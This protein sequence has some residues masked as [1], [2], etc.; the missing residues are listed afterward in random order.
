MVTRALWGGLLGLCALRLLYPFYNSPVIQ[1]VGMSGRQ[2]KQAGGFLTPEPMAGVDS[3]LYQAWLWALR[4]LSNDHAF[5][6]QLVCGLLCAVLPLCWYA[7][8]RQLLPQKWA[9]IA[10]ILI[11]L[12][13]SF[14]TIYGYFASET[15]LLPLIGLACYASLH[16]LRT[17]AP[18]TLWLAVLLWTLAALTRVI[19]LPAGLLC[20]GLI[21]WKMGFR[22]RPMLLPLLTSLI[23]LG[24]SAEH[25]HK[26]VNVYTPFGIPQLNALLA[27]S[28]ASRINIYFDG[29][30]YW[31]RSPA[32]STKPLS[33]LSDW[34]MSPRTP[35]I[36]VHIVTRQGREAWAQ[37]MEKYPFDAT[38]YARHLSQTVMMLLFSPSWPEVWPDNWRNENQI[39][40][41]EEALNKYARWLWAPLIIGVFICAARVPLAE[42]QH[43]FI[44]LTLSLLIIMAL[45]YT[46]LFEGRYR[47]PVE[48]LLIISA[49]TLLYQ[50][51]QRSIG[52]A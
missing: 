11:G 8:A 14:L 46:A 33:P 37:A 45:Q 48:P 44:L 20:I 27:R 30:H 15:L 9:L 10:A 3:Y 36:S 13:P 31:F 43:A 34:H 47:K 19:A 39:A 21:W 38:H 23:L 22:L 52:H 16:C 40:P 28:D 17:P 49:I 2:W 24:I 42:H 41:W 32:A 6:I 18:R 29:R 26:A 4:S 1:M 7:C 5:T 25:H 50:H 12:H 35:P 51:R